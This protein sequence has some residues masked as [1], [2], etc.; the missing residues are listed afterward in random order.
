MKFYFLQTCCASPEQYD[1]Y[2]E[3]GSLCGYIRLRWGELYAEYPCLNGEVIYHHVF[4]DNFKGCFE[5]E[6]RDEYLQLI[7]NKYAERVMDS[8]VS[9]SSNVKVSYKL[10]TDISQ[11]EE[12]ING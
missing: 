3:S 9:Y 6:E 1:V 10:L 4:Q 11:L 5:D 8:F 7:A 12:E 2:R